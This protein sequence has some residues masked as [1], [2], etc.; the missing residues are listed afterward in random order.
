MKLLTKKDDPKCIAQL[1]ALRVFQEND[2][3]D[4]FV[5]KVNYVENSIRLF[6]QTSEIVR[7]NYDDAIQ[8]AENMASDNGF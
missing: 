8:D 1:L 7:I 6:S 3:N 5:G 4:Y 2:N